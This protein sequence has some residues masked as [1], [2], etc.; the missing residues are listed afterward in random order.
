MLQCP[1]KSLSKGR[2]LLVRP[3]LTDGEVWEGPVGE[4]VVGVVLL[5]PLRLQELGEEVGIGEGIRP[6]RLATEVEEDDREQISAE[7]TG[8]EREIATGRTG[9]FRLLDANHHLRGV[10]EAGVTD[11]VEGIGIRALGRA[12]VP[13]LHQGGD[14]RSDVLVNVGFFLHCVC[15]ISVMLRLSTLSTEKLQSFYVSLFL[16]MCY[17]VVLFS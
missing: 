9:V 14:D 17:N 16:K 13:G 5:L 3:R 4:I 2:R 7:G 11:V 10:E 1:P 12:L 8:K 6:R 15:L